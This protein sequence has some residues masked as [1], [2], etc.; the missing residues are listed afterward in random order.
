MVAHSSTRHSE[1]SLALLIGLVTALAATAVAIFRIER[2][3]I[4]PRSN[5]YGE[6]GEFLGI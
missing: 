3:G 1:F 2:E 4:A 6:W 5:A